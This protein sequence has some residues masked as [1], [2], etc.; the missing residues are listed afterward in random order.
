[1]TPSLVKQGSS[2]TNGVINYTESVTDFMACGDSN[3]G[4]SPGSIVFPL[5]G[6]LSYYLCFPS[7]LGL[8]TKYIVY[9]LLFVKSLLCL[10]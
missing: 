8:Y 9:F 6:S 1:M 3:L 10:L 5:L 7:K 2:D 4:L